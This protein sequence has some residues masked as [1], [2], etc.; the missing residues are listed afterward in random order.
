MKTEGSIILHTLI[1]YFYFK[2]VGLIIFMLQF[3]NLTCSFSNYKTA[4]CTCVLFFLFFYYNIAFSEGTKQ[5]MP[6]SADNGC[7]QFNDVGR[8]FA[9]MSNTDSLQRLYFHIKSITEKV[10]FGFAKHSSSSATSGQFR[11]KDPSGTIVYAA[12]NLPTSGAGFI[13]TYAQAV[14]GPKI[15]GIPAAGY[16]PLN[17]TPSVTGDF[18]IEFSSNSNRNYRFQ[19]FD[20]T[21]VDASSKTINGRLWSYAWDMNTWSSANVF[22]GSFYVYTNEGYVSKVDL[23]GIQ[24]FGF[25]VSCNNTG[26]TNTG[27]IVADR[28]SIA[29]NSTRPFFKIFLSDPDST[30]YLSASP[31]ALNNPISVVDGNVYYGQSAQFNA[32]V[33]GTGIIQLIISLNGISGYQPGTNDAIV[34]AIVTTGNNIIFWDGKDAYGNYPLIGTSIEISAGFSSGITHLPIYDA[35]TQSGGYNI[36]RIRPVTGPAPIRWDDSN[37]IGGTVNISGSSGNGHSWLINFGNIRTMNT[38]WNGYE[39]ENLSAFTVTVMPP[40][41]IEL[42]SFAAKPNIDIIDI[43]WATASE[44]NNNYF[45]VEK[46]KDCLRFETISNVA[47]AGNSNTVLNYLLKDNKPYDGVSYYRLSQT[48]FDGTITHSHLI[49]VNFNRKVD[50][51]FKIYP[52]PYD[53]I[54]IKLDMIANRGDETKLIITDINGKEIYSK[55]ITINSNDE[56]VYTFCSKE[57]LAQGIYFLKVFSSEKEYTKKVVVE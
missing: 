23:N 11:I 43:N 4:K 38:W 12:T 53:G 7:T 47:G 49:S 40:L 57:R 45:S 17:F 3:K 30:I 44:K 51:V 25:V 1:K 52:N 46:T 33:T 24:P 22:N 42:I 31:P 5:F 55:E 27:N 54:C 8:P 39:I 14:A 29:G 9:L 56:N 19:Y 34:A 35:E 48:D 6:A 18:Y 32:D 20:I 10:Y 26:P 2:K 21:V 37:F 50:F 41:P 16:S 36:T 28:K 15:S 13:S